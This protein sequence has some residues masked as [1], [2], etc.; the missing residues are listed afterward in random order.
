MKL[1]IVI[2]CLL[3]AL[4][5]SGAPVSIRSTSLT[6][7][8]EAFGSCKEQTR[9]V[10]FHP[11]L[12]VVC[13]NGELGFDTSVALKALVRNHA[14]QI[15]FV[16]ITSPGGYLTPALDMADI[17]D[18]NE[19][20]VVV[21]GVCASSCA[22]F[23]FMAGRVKYLLDG[24]ILAFHGG[25]ISDAKIAKMDVSNKNKLFLKEE[26]RRFKVFYKRMGLNMEM[27][28]KPPA[29]VEEKLRSGKI[30]FWT[31]PVDQLKNFGVKNIV[32]MGKDN[33]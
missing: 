12:S 8:G 1:L 29:W 10:S 26:N 4:S 14:G 24:A 31:W 7:A 32:S 20:D 11:E 5:S 9:G 15:K 17:I 13:I 16:V 28:T 19:Y 21:G 6:S 33:G 27:L 3:C 18:R 2:V 30:I 23:L 22:Q 25:P